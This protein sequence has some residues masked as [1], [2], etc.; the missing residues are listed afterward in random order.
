M[1]RPALAVVGVER[2]DRPEVVRRELRFGL[3]RDARDRAAR[4][5]FVPRLRLQRLVPCGI[6]QRT[7]WRSHVIFAVVGWP[8]S[9]PMRGRPRWKQRAPSSLTTMAAAARGDGIAPDRRTLQW[10]TRDH[11]SEHPS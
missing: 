2:M 3:A 8:A 11:R 10:R 1:E 5:V 7:G 6:E 4:T 9:V